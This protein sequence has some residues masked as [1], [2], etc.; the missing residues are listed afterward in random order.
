MLNLKFTEVR[1][2]HR[3]AEAH[4]D[5]ARSLLACCPEKT[6]STRG[7][8]VVYLCGYVVECSLKALLLMQL[9]S[10]QH[11]SFVIWLKRELKHDL[12]RLRVELITRGVNIP[13]IQHENFK[14]V[15][16]SWY[17]EMRYRME[18][19]TRDKTEKVF[20]A[21]EQLFAWVKGG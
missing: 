8:E 21:A 17:S 16:S 14:R 6:S 7:H 19:W 10:K 12:E 2:F 9:P 3:A 18:A 1:R 5:A 20:T 11:G 13:R 15:R 4:L